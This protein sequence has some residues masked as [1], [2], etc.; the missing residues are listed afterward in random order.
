MIQGQERPILLFSKFNNTKHMDGKETSF[1][2]FCIKKIYPD[3]RNKISLTF[4]LF[5]KI[6]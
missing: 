6:P 2:W 5:L 4:E 1:E 3:E